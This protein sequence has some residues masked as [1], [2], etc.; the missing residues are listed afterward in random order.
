[1]HGWPDASSA[2]LDQVEVASPILQEYQEFGNIYI[3][4]GRKELKKLLDEANECTVIIQGSEN[5]LSSTQ[6]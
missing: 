3:F 6:Q 4:G 1:M 2:S 5:V